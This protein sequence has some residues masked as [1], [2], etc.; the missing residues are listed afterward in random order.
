MAGAESRPSNPGE[1]VDDGPAFAHRRR[2]SDGREY[3]IV[4]VFHHPEELQDTL[5]S[6]GWSVDLW[7]TGDEFFYGVARLPGVDTG[8]HPGLTVD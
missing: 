8:F 3:T 6:L 2:L 4:K 7:T 5:A 1:S